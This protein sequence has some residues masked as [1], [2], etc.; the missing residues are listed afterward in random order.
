MYSSVVFDECTSLC[1][2]QKIKT[3]KSSPTPKALLE[4]LCGQLFLPPPDSWQP[5]MCSCLFFSFSFVS[6][7]LPFGYYHIHGATHYVTSFISHNA[8][9]VRL[10]CGVPVVCACW[11]TVQMLEPATVA[12]SHSLKVGSRFGSTPLSVS[13]VSLELHKENMNL[14]K[15]IPLK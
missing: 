7:V 4:L 3:E 11:P 12:C 10:C 6:L 15:A 5:L 1:N 8:F 2:W 13:S 14:G 9:G